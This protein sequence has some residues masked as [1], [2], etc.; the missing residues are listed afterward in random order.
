MYAIETNTQC[1]VGFSDKSEIVNTNFEACSNIQLITL[2]AS[3]LQYF[4]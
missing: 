4:R 2:N 3:Q 1:D